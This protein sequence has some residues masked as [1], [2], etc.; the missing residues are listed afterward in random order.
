MT[1][2]FAR[3][4]LLEKL[5]AGPKELS[6]KYPPLKWALAEGYAEVRG[7]RY[8][9][10]GAGSAALAEALMDPALRMAVSKMLP[11]L[12]AK[13]LCRQSS[14]TEEAVIDGGGYLYFIEPG[15]RAFPPVSAR[16]LIEHGYL[17]GQG[18]GLFPDS[19]QT[20]VVARHG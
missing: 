3:R 4:T 6:P 12:G 17:A 19:S 10:T 7:D 20:F 15:H 11:R 13:K 1:M 2:S 8:A 5:S 16:L 18:D 14:S 9:I